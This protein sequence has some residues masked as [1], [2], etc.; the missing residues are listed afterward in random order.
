MTTQQVSIL[1]T[2][3]AQVIAGLSADQIS[4]LASVMV[5]APPTLHVSTPSVPNVPSAPAWDDESTWT[6]EYLETLSYYVRDENGR[7]V[8][9]AVTNAPSLRHAADRLGVR[10]YH[11]GKARRKEELLVAVKNGL[12]IRNAARAN[13]KHKAV[14]LPAQ[15]AP[16]TNPHG[17]IGTP[18]ARA[19]HDGTPNTPENVQARVDAANTYAKKLYEYTMAN[20]EPIKK[21]IGDETN[22]KAIQTLLRDAGVKHDGCVYRNSFSAYAKGW[23][24]AVEETKNEK[25]VVRRTGDKSAQHDETLPNI[26]GQTRKM[27]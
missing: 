18:P 1:Q 12:K 25:L 8:P 15:P 16:G 20:A 22:A 17:L 9:L 19:Q 3:E 11:G 26:W 10:L 14:I 13:T 21:L 7:V 6:P 4:A 2:M 24:A 27:S 23:R 5:D